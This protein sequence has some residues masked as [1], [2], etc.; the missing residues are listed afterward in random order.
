MNISQMASLE[1]RLS[2][3]VGSSSEESANEGEGALREPPVVKESTGFHLGSG[4][5]GDESSEEGEGTLVGPDMEEAMGGN[6]TGRGR[7]LS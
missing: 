3:G 2:L 4:S 5:S 7:D 1:E 6:S